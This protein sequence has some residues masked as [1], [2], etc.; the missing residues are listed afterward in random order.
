MT[1]TTLAAFVLVGA[2]RA[3]RVLGQ[4]LRRRRLRLGR[5]RQQRDA[6]PAGARQGRA[7]PAGSQ[8]SVG[9]SAV[10][11]T[12]RARTT[13]PRWTSRSPPWRR[14]SRR[15]RPGS[16]PTHR[17]SQTL[18]RARDDRGTSVTP[19][20]AAAPCRSRRQRRQRAPGAHAV[21]QLLRAVPGT[22]FPEK[23]GPGRRHRCAWSTSRPSTASWRRSASGRRRRSTR[24]P[25]PVRSGPTS[26]RSRR[27]RSRR[28]RQPTEFEAEQR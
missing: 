1:R 5:R 27:S 17:R 4:R 25:G 18:L 15:S 6:V 28:S 13:S 16:S 20:S 3:H 8:L 24:S 9:D 22:P 21:R 7:D 2:L 10:V 14:R 26:R 11:A 23:F 19:T 12:T